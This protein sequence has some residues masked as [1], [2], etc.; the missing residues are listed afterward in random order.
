M[1]PSRS[2][3]RQSGPCSK[4][5]TYSHG[6]IQ[7]RN[8][9]R[10]RDR[11]YSASFRQRVHNMRIK[12]C[13][14]PTESVAESLRRTADRKY[15]PRMFRPHGGPARRTSPATADRVLPILS[16]LAHTPG[17]GHG[18]SAAT[19]QSNGQR[20]AQSEKSQRW[21][22]CIT[23]MSGERRDDTGANLQFTVATGFGTHNR[24]GPSRSCAL[25]LHAPVGWR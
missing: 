16:S 2:I 15:P 24:P 11:I 17:A 4:W 7:P 3:L 25:P 13:S 12:K 9:L 6:I 22:G 14:S 5:W 23:I 8:L 19:G 21:A 20:M 1:F 18:L 10:D